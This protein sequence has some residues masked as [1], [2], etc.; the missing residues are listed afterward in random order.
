MEILTDV[1]SGLL[2]LSLIGLIVVIAWMII[3]AIRLKDEFCRSGRRLGGPVSSTTQIIAS[4]KDAVDTNGVRVR[5]IVKRASVTLGALKE[6]K[7]QAAVVAESIR[8]INFEPLLQ[9]TRELLRVA[10]I[11]LEIFRSAGKQR[12]GSS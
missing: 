4:G 5:R 6:T 10:T 8:E 9:N 1:L 2:I 11:V 3:G 12:K 7:D